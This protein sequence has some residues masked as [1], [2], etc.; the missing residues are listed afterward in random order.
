MARHPKSRKNTIIAEI[1][2]GGL[3]MIDF[4]IMERSIKTAWINT[5]YK[6]VMPRGKPSP[7]TRSVNS[8]VLIFLLNATSIFKS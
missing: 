7:I 2:H 5:L 6:I 3:K 4:E 1:K 8:A